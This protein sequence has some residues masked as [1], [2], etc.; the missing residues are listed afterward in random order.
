MGTEDFEHSETTPIKYRVTAENGTSY[1]DY[2]IVV[3]MLPAS[4]DNKLKTFDFGTLSGKIDHDAG[5]V[6]L[7]LPAGSSNRFAPSITLPEFA[8]VEPASGVLQ[9]FTEPA[10]YTVTAQNGEIKRYTVTVTVSTQRQENPDKSKY[11]SLLNTIIDK[12]RDSASDDWEWMQLGIYENQQQSSG[13]NTNN[14]FSIAKEIKDLNVGPN[15]TMT[16]VARLIMLL[17][18]RGYDCSNLAQYNDD[19][20]FTDKVGNQIDNLVANLLETKSGTIFGVSFGLC[21]LDMGTYSVPANAARTRESLL[22]TLLQCTFDP[23]GMYGMDEVGM[24]MYAIAPYQ[25]DPVYGERVRAKLD[26]G[27]AAIVKY[28]REDYT[29]V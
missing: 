3:K 13:P 22:D 23:P 15:G 18:S 21:A 28:V 4:S 29:F 9:D 1:Q 6:T 12:Y 2:S 11:E 20:P 27:V 17:T 8:T 19:T 7:E 14:G 16:D 25:D 5:T 24:V 10:V 26:D